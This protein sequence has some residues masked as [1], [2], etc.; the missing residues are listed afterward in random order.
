MGR[1]VIKHFS[2]WDK[3]LVRQAD[4]EVLY[5]IVSRKKFI[6]YLINNTWFL[7]VPL[8]SSAYGKSY[9]ALI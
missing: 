3:N 6:A 8:I 9:V 7:F 2:V 1:W 4:V 5:N